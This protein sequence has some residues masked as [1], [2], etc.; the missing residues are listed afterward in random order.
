MHV[1]QDWIGLTAVMQDGVKPIPVY[2][3][4]DG[5]Q[6]FVSDDPYLLQDGKSLMA[7]IPAV[8]S[9]GP[10][11]IDASGNAVDA[12]PVTIVPGSAPPEPPTLASGYISRGGENL[13]RD[14]DALSRV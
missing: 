4:D 10:I 7:P 2:Q 9:G 12:V 5:I 3:K 1:K 6:T 8:D 11:W 13:N 14:G